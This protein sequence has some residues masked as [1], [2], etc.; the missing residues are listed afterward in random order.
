MGRVGGE[1]GD[2][3]H[4]AGEPGVAWAWPQEPGGAGPQSRQKGAIPCL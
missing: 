4:G 3:I 1:W 2:W